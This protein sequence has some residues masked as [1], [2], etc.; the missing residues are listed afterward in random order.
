MRFEE[1]LAELAQWLEGQIAVDQ[2]PEAHAELA[3]AGAHAMK[4]SDAINAA[5]RLPGTFRHRGVVSP[6]RIS[7]GWNRYLA[8]MKT[9]RRVPAE[10]RDLLGR[11]VHTAKGKTGTTG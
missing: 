10:D 3:S 7:N 6:G 1:G 2:R 4:G 5:R 9:D 11:L 8:D